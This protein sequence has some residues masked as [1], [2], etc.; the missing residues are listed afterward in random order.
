VVVVDASTVVAACLAADGWT[1]LRGEELLA[2]PLALSEASSVIHEARWRGE[3]TPDVAR[4]ALERLTAAPVTF[5][6]LESPLFAWA[7]ADE[8][9][10]AKTYDAE[11]VA[12]A[13][14]LNCRLVTLDARL[15]RGA[16][17]LAEIVGPTEL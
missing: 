3:L 16:G 9:G 5:R 10:W 7:V 14:A 17:R 11:Y 8:L 15:R 1:P 13:R 12:L 4:R 6:T 2:P